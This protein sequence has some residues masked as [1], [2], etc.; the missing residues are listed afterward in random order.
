[1]QGFCTIRLTAG[2]MWDYWFVRNVTTFLSIKIASTTTEKVFGLCWALTG[3]TTSRCFSHSSTAWRRC[4]ALQLR[5]TAIQSCVPKHRVP[6]TVLSP[7]VP[8]GREMLL[9]SLG[10]LQR[11]R[12]DRQRNS[13]HDSPHHR[14][15]ELY[16]VSRDRHG[17]V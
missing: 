8:E 11:S 17:L 2:K 14:A 4:R 5:T 15:L 3:I 12:R 13:H 9:L 7:V 10:S 1:M 6:C 16:R